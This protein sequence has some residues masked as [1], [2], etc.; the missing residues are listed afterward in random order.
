MRGANVKQTSTNHN[1]TNTT[2][3]NQRDIAQYE[4]LPTPIFNLLTKRQC[5]ERKEMLYL[6]SMA[7]VKKNN[8][9]QVVLV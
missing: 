3:P 7:L 5:P 9:M 8:N 1:H 6:K 2:S 4:W